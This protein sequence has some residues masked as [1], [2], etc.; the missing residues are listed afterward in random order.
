MTK[1]H[2]ADESID[3]LQWTGSNL[4]AVQAL[5]AAAVTRVIDE[6]TTL[7]IQAADGS[8]RVPVDG[9]VA[10]NV[11]GVASAMTAAQLAY[12]TAGV[13]EAVNAAAYTVTAP[14]AIPAGVSEILLNHATVPVVKTIASLL[15]HPGFLLI[16][17]VSASG[18]AAHTVT[19]TTGTLDGTN[20]VATLNAPGESLLVYVDSLGNGSIVANVGVVALS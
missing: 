12:F 7:V 2:L 17:D 4:E 6:V 3:V 13:N 9:Y 14:A 11:N 1:Y 16:K 15:D 10:V 8:T 20:K 19:V 5:H 18:T